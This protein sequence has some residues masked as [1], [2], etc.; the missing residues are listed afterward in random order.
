M[1][2]HLE[3]V[4]Y[5]FARMDV[6]G[7]RVLLQEP[8]YYDV[9]KEAFLE[10]LENLFS[11]YRNEKPPTTQFQIFSGVCCNRKCDLHLG[12][13]AFRFIAESGCCTDLRFII[14]QSDDGLDVV[15]DIYTCN[16]LMTHEIS[17]Y[18]D[19]VR[20]LCVY[21]D[22]KFTTT[23]PTD[24]AILLS[25]ALEAHSNWLEK[26]SAGLLTVDEIRIWLANHK[27][28]YDEI[29]GL[30]GKFP[31]IWKW[32]KFLR[33]YYDLNLFITMLDDLLVDVTKLHQIE[34]VQPNDED[35]GQWIV[36]IEKII[37]R[38]YN[39]VYGWFYESERLESVWKISIHVN[40][41]FHTE[42]PLISQL[43]TFLAWFKRE[44]KR[45]VYHNFSL[46]SAE[47]DEFLETTKSPYRIYQVCRLLSYHLDI[48]EKF[49]KEG[50][51]IPFELGVFV[52]P[53]IENR[54]Y[55][56]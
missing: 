5:C 20:F 52:E 56:E 48:R 15:K 44:Q 55:W 40:T 51:F 45:L 21:E 26:S 35:L 22:D 3:K 11:D 9:P 30:E 2:T 38:K 39:L 16:Q 27:S 49:R 13:I 25:Q 17:P 18:N 23:L 24:Y 47:V 33:P 37:E 8:T 31:V 28:L 29:G 6:E 32:D 14:D 42:D 10:S 41:Q 12:N 50:V 34:G 4:L 1:T 54:S 7:L 36:A 19:T 53:L 43:Q 46:N